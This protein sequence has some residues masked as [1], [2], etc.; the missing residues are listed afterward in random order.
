MLDTA[1][2]HTWRPSSRSQSVRDDRAR[3]AAA[4]DDGVQFPDDAGARQRRIRD[5][6]QAFPREV[7]DDGQNPEPPTICEG[8]ADEIQAP[9]LVH[10]AWRDH[11]PSRS[12]GPL[13]AATLADLELLLPVKPPQLLLV[14]HDPL[15]FKHDVDAPIAE[16]ASFGCHR[17]HRS[18]NDGIIR[19]DACVANA[20]AIDEKSFARPTLA[21]PMPL[22][23]VGHSTSLGIERHH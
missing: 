3:P 21:H 2:G 18:S 14:H 6:C 17:L 20:R 15:P 4:G 8:V 1:L 12:Q 13:A 5:Q 16:A 9:A 10:P 7:V 22:A 11:R 19:P 23:G